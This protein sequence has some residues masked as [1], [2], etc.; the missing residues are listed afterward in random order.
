MSGSQLLVPG[1]SAERVFREQQAEGD[2]GAG[3]QPLNA[4]T[5]PGPDGT[6]AGPLAPG[7]YR[8]DTLTAPFVALQI[9]EN[10]LSLSRWEDYHNKKASAEN[11]EN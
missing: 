8:M 6:A 3:S 1:S 5:E 7:F 4:P 9:S 11:A 10:I 2:N